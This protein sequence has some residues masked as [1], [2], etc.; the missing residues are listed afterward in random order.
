MLVF[1]IRLRR[2]EPEAGTVAGPE[3]GK[4]SARKLIAWEEKEMSIMTKM[5]ERDGGLRKAVGMVEGQTHRRSPEECWDLRERALG[6][7]TDHAI[8]IL[9]S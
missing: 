6:I 5:E 4:G 2:V 7:L 9:A 3:E 8:H 1:L